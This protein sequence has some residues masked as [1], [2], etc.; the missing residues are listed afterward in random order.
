MSLPRVVVDVIVGLKSDQRIVSRNI[1]NLLLDSKSFVYK[2]IVPLAL[3]PT[4]TP[5]LTPALI[6]SLTPALESGLTPR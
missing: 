1:A 3:T 4:L 2:L 6:S 5:A